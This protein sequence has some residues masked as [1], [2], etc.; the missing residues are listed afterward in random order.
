MLTESEISRGV[1]RAALLVRW[2]M[3]VYAALLLLAF[4]LIRSAGDR[5]EREPASGQAI[6]ADD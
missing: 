5:R 3:L 6:E 1:R 2:R 4:A